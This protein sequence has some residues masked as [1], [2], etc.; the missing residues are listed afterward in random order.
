MSAKAAAAI[1]IKP[2]ADGWGPG[3]R[4]LATTPGGTLYAT[5]PGGSLL[6]YFR[7]ELAF[8]DITVNCF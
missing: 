7:H 3:P 5:T 6:H 2:R 1:N 8:I 4:D